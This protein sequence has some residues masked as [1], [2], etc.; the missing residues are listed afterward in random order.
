MYT[1]QFGTDSNIALSPSCKFISNQR[2]TYPSRVITD[3]NW[4]WSCEVS[5][6][7]FGK[8]RKT[9]QQSI[10]VCLKSLLRCEYLYNHTAFVS[11]NF[12]YFCC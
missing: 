9:C 2:A 1:E 8:F 12:L 10:E 3:L 7:L 4:K 11:E 5:E 6:L